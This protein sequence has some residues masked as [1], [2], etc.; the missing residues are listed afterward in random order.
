MTSNEMMN[1]TIE[2]IREM[3]T[4]INKVHESCY[5]SYHIL[6]YII[7]YLT[8]HKQVNNTGF[9]KEIIG[10]LNDGTREKEI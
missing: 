6:V 1:M 3:P 8:D 5:R 9:I 4:C 10:Y 2:R 7:R